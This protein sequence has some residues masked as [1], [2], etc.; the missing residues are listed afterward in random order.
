MRASH[1][2]ARLKAKKIC[3]SIAGTRLSTFLTRNQKSETIQLLGGGRRARRGLEAAR[4]KPPPRG[5]AG[6]GGAGAR[7]ARPKKLDGEWAR[8]AKGKLILLVY[9]RRGSG[10]AGPTHSVTAILEPRISRE[11][12]GNSHLMLMIRCIVNSAEYFWL[13]QLLRW[14]LTKEQA[15]S[16]SFGLGDAQEPPSRRRR[17]ACAP[18]ARKTATAPLQMP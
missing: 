15:I 5:S 17:P 14:C 10:L 1:T 3:T 7:A 8:E 2:P 12:R 4:K 18:N 11:F 13:H 6:G 9:P 16:R